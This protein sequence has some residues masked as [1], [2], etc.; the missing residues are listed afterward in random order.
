MAE[1]ADDVNIRWIFYYR[2]TIFT[3]KPLLSSFRI[4]EGDIL[5]GEGCC[6]ISKTLETKTIIIHIGGTRLSLVLNGDEA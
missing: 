5:P 6:S 4:E 1:Q 2:I 3:Y